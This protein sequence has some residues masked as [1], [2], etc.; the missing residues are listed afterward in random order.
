VLL[1]YPT[2]YKR[3]KDAISDKTNIPTNEIYAG[4]VLRDH[5]YLWTD[6]VFDLMTPIFN[7]KFG[8]HVL[9]LR[10]SEVKKQK[11]VRGIARLID[12]KIN[13]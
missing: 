3:V 9:K 8:D 10:R 11:T 4:H 5:P 13:K 2:I 6:Q 12:G 7:R 1:P